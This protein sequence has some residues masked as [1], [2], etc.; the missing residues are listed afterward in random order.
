MGKDLLTAPEIRKTIRQRLLDLNVNFYKVCRRSL[1]WDETRIEAFRKF[2]NTT[3][4]NNKY[5][6]QNIIDFCS[7]IGM[8]I[9]VTLIIDKEFQP[10]KKLLNDG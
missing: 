9:K 10:S 5:D 1:S 3:T 2:L 8:D 4:Y 7:R 6:H